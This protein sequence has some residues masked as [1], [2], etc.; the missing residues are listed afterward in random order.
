M[1]R[2]KFNFTRAKLRSLPSPENGWKYFYDDAVRGLALGVGA[3]G[4]KSFRVNRKFK[5]RAVKVTLGVFDPDLPETRELPAGTE[6]LDLLGH[7]PALNVRM[8][9]KLATAVTA[10][11]DVGINPAAVSTEARH[12]MT[13]GDLFKRYAAHRRAEGKKTV[14]ALVWTWERYLGDLPESPQK[15]HGA[16][17]SKS[18]G[19]VNWER[20][21]LPEVSYEQVSRL[22]LDLGEKVGHT[23]ANRVI[24]MLSAMYN[25]ARKQR[26]Y[27][28]ENPAE[29]SGKFQLKSRERF[30]QADEVHRFFQALDELPD[31]QDFADYI[32]ISLFA[33]ARRNN[34]LRMRWDELNLDGARW[35][36]A[37]EVMKNG[38]PL[39]IPLVEEV[40]EILQRRSWA[41]SIASA[42]SEK[43]VSEWVFPGGTEAGHMGPQRKLWLQL[44]KAARLPD[45]RLHD[46]RRS[47]GSW[48]STT[49]SNTV[50]TM[51]ALGHKTIDASLIYQRLEIAPVRDAMQR[52][53]SEL[54]QFSEGKS[55]K[56]IELPRPR[57]SSSRAAR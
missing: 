51:L 1:A 39:T 46:L 33:G 44:V 11:L 34:V 9:R 41:C 47:L 32:R 27:R 23:T 18:P 43:A 25:F 26:L 20:R 6:P 56:F 4:S 10:Q 45:L 12:S 53:V 50:M 22:R 36:I 31:Q 16:K 2:D 57:K 40:V 13:L 17:R 21:R 30:L 19:A 48:M 42:A 5:G 55:P 15:S 3:G 7:S 8:A 35:T 54:V 38:D 52:A 49:G 24:E 14:P 28:G 29:G 37:G